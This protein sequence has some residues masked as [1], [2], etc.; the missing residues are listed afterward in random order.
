MSHREVQSFELGQ[1]SALFRQMDNSFFYSGMRQ[2]QDLWEGC[3]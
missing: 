2:Q 1:L 3:Q